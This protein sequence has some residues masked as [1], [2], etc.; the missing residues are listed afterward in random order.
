MSSLRL[1]ARVELGALAA[2]SVSQFEE[3]LKGSDMVKKR[4]SA[5]KR[6]ARRKSAKPR[7][8][9]KTIAVEAARPGKIRLTAREEQIFRL[10]SLGCSVKE[11][12]AILDVAPST[13]VNHKARLMAKLGTD[14]TA[15][16]T[17]LAIRYGISPMDDR[18]TP[19]EQRLSG[20]SHDGWN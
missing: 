14:K 5:K 3:A 8:P 4:R 1:E 9:G 7:R 20:R 19:S 12:G 2:H 10:V 17:R 13:A 15:L 18:L 11:V 16:L 6:T